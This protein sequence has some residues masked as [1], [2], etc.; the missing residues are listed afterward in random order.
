MVECLCGRILH[1]NSSGLGLIIISSEGHKF[2]LSMLG[3]LH[4]ATNN[5]P[6]Y[7]AIIIRLEMYKDL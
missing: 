2:N 3:D 1:S 7:E 5:E 4:F 6:K